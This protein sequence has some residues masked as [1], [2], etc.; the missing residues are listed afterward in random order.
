MHLKSVEMKG[1]TSWYEN[2][3]TIKVNETHESFAVMI[4]IIEKIK[5]CVTVPWSVIAF[6]AKEEVY[7]NDK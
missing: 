2:K 6:S 3:T 1:S 4:I 5:M 7:M